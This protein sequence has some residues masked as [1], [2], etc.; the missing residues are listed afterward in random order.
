[1]WKLRLFQGESEYNFVDFEPLCFAQLS[2]G[3]RPVLSESLGSAP[4]CR[5]AVCRG[6]LKKPAQNSREAKIRAGIGKN[7]I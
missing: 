1:M 5:L 2:W 4:H 6:K 3:S 7:E